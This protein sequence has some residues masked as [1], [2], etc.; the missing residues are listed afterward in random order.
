MTG[1]TDYWLLVTR[2]DDPCDLTKK[3]LDEALCNWTCPE[4]REPTVQRGVDIVLQHAPLSLPLNF[5]Q[6]TGMHVAQRAFLAALGAADVGRDLNVGRVFDAAGVEIRELA[7]FHGKEKLVVRGN[8]KST[9]RICETC[10]RISY[11]PLGQYY[12]AVRPSGDHQLYTTGL[13]LILTATM[14][15]TIRKQRWP[16]IRYF[17][18]PILDKPRD[19]RTIF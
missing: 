6:A 15:N 2:S 16:K 9:Y 14:H 3:G 5:V 12:L 1:A 17:R 7:S 8:Q 18:L 11:F 10:K 13:G 19:G 4:C